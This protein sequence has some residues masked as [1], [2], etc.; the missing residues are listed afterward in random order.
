MPRRRAPRAAVAKFAREVNATIAVVGPE[1]PLE[2]GVADALWAIGVK[3]V[4]PKQHLAQLESSKA[5]TRDLLI[6]NGIGACPKYKVATSLD[7]CRRF[8]AALPPLGYVVKADGLCGGKGVKVGGEHLL[9]DDE[10]LAFCAELLA[11]GG[12]SPR[13]VLE[14]KLIGQEFSLMSFCDGEAC[15]HIPP[16]QDHKRA[17]E[18]DKGPNTGGM[19]TYSGAN[20]T[21]PFLAHADIAHAQVRRAGSGVR[22]G[23]GVRAGAGACALGQGRARCVQARRR[24]QCPAAASARSCCAPPPPPNPPPPPPPP[25]HPPPPPPHTPAPPS[26]GAA[27]HKKKRTQE[28]HSHHQTLHRPRQLRLR[29]SGFNN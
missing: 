25:P 26:M 21:L 23:R 7:E 16:I 6:K 28:Q 13:V 17:H 3:C 5:F 18:G 10:S 15:A 1:G 19:G 14:E 8:F 11:A 12:D 2:A 4:G 9:T 20:R 22:G 24:A 27:R 29:E